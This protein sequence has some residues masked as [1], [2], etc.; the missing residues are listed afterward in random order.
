[1]DGT[2]YNMDVDDL[3]GDSEH[4]NIQT[5]NTTPPV[6]GRD[7]RIDELGSTGCCQKI[8][9]SKNGCVAYITPDG[10]SVNLKIFSRNSE[11]GKWALG[12]PVP[13]ELPQGSE[14]FPLIHLSW[15]HLGNDLAVMDQAGRVMIFSCAMA[16]D[17]MHFTRAEIAHPESEVDA[18]VGMHWL[19][20]LP[21]AQKNLIAWS[22]AREGNKW[23]WNIRQ[24]LFNNAHHPVDGKASLIYLK[25]YGELKLRFQQNDNNWQEASTQ[26]G[27]MISTKES[28]THA[29][30]ASNNDN[31]LL[32]AAYDVKRRLHLYRVET[33]WNVPADKRS[34]NAGPFEKPTIQVSLLALEDTCNPVDMATD[35]LSNGGTSESAATAAAQLTHLD[36]LPVTPQQDDGS[37]PTIQAIFSKPPNPISYDM[38]PQETRYSIIV[39][40]QVHQEQQNQLH[41]SL[42]QVTSKKK[43]VS[44]L[45]AQ[46]TFLLKRQP[47]FALHSVVLDFY[48]MWYNMLLAFCYSDGSIEFRKRSTMEVIMPDDNT[49]N[50]TSLLQAGFIFQHAEPSLHVAFSP[51][52]CVAVGMQLDGTTKL[53]LME[54]THGTLSTDDDDPHHSAALAAL[55]LQSSSAANQYFSSDDIFA[56]IDSM[57]DKRKQDFITLL[58]EGL[59]VNID[60]GIDDSSTNHFILLGRSPFFVKTLSAMHLLGLQGTI[61]RTLVSKT[62]WQILNIKYVT[63]ILTTIVRMHGDVSKINLRPEAVPQMIGTIR[64]TMHFMAYILDDL[65]ALGRALSDIPPADLTRDVL[66]SK[67]KETNKP[68]ILLLLSAFPRAMMKLWAQPIQWVKRSAESQAATSNPAGGP[69][70][71]QS[72]ESK[73]LY[74]PLL[75]A[76]SELPFEWRWFEILVTETTAHIR[77]IYKQRN[78]NDAQRNSIEREILLGKIPDILFPVAKRLVTDTLWNSNQQNACLA[79]KLDM[80]KLMFFDTTWLG[81]TDSKRARV[82]HEEHVVDVCQKMIIRGTGT[83]VHP[84]NTSGH[85]LM[86]RGRS[87]SLQSA[88]G[89]GGASAGAT[90]NG[91]SN[92]ERKARNMLRQCVRCGACMEDVVPGLQGYTIHHYQWLVGVSK[93]CVCGNSWMLVETKPSLK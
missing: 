22:A 69:V 51:N 14:V 2:S 40:W 11:T 89:G 86:G 38:N 81:F 78:L 28:F 68:A 19:A 58:F 3:F 20:I 72:P 80:G 32:L 73:R 35:E 67:I 5:I 6:K 21:Y 24:H 79:D 46:T 77:A 39:K 13:L 84:V 90:A 7:A 64:W 34:Q 31:T 65:F 93:H 16:L 37:V 92:A 70:P 27:P 50:V 71:V 91:E 87:D 59:Q 45:P 63:Q 1:M 15:S 25:R 10:Y 26:L 48:P 47:D 33:I 49:D 60:C 74:T 82:W 41:P 62:A 23:K 57:S 4:V 30:F 54:Y 52:H 55:I 75:T 29:A 36:F 44:S 56:I 66:E 8:S 76:V 18:V 83:W 43:S 88:A 61:N 42:E 85:H 53:R 9:W 17:R 12:K